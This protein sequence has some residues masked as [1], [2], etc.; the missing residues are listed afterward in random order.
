MLRLTGVEAGYGNA[1]VLREVDLTVP[2]GAVVALLG[3]NGAGKTTLLNVASGLITPT[4]GTVHLDG[5]DVVGL[6]PH[7]RA[8]RG[9]CHVPE[10]RGVFPTLTV[11]DNLELYAAGGDLDRALDAF[12][13]L[14]D[15]L[16]QVAGTLSGGEQQ[17][18]AL[19]RTYVQSP[20]IVLLDEVSM[21]LAPRLVDEI[22]GFIERLAAEGV[23]MLLV[24]QYV[25]RALEL[26]DYVY[27]LRRGRIGFAGEPVEL[28]DGDLFSHYVGS[29]QTPPT[30]VRAGAPVPL[31]PREKVDAYLEAGWWSPETWQDLLARHVAERPAEIAVVD[32]LNREDLTEGD[33]QR[34]T[35]ADLEHRVDRLAGVLAAHGIVAGDVVGFQLANGVELVQSLLAITRIGAIASPFPAQYREHELT[36]LGELAGIRVFLTSGQLLGRPNAEAGLKLQAMLPQLEHVMAWGSGLPDGVVAL[37]SATGLT[38]VDAHHGDPN[39]CTT[40]CWTS[41]TESVPKGVPRCPLDWGALAQATVDAGK[42]TSDDVL[43]NPFPMVN[44]AGIGGM[45]VPWL[46]SGARLVQH[47]P[48]DLMT[49]LKQVM[50]EEVTYT[51]A[52]PALLNVLVDNEKILSMVDLSSIRTIG[53]GSAPLSPWMIKAWRDRHGIDVTNF[54]GSNEG[55]ALIGDPG[56]IPD[57]EDRARYFPRFGVEGIEW[58][59]HRV[60]RGIRTRL[61]DLD[62]GTDITETGRP[63]E[64]RIAGPT[65]FA[66]YLHGA[67]P[68]A[69]DEQGYFGTGDVFELVSLDGGE[70]RF[71]KFVD[72]AKDV[73]IRGGMNIAPAELEALLGDHPKIAD[74]AVIGYPDDDLGERTCAVVVPSGEGTPTLGELLDHLREQQIASYKLPE[75]IEIVAVLPRNAVGKVLKRELREQVL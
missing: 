57:P 21:G 16:G 47:H 62:D 39:D 67:G 31:H 48:F 61:V 40:I 9:L 64:L 22:F 59:D 23:A 45:F 46:L 3:P 34:W 11:R 56:S 5:Q 63:G 17:M 71:L 8:A 53:S 7:Q 38:T 10:G 18:L 55:I 20:R 26:A 12:P 70:P 2:P 65:V 49:F 68:D 60:A 74:V 25:S 6:A 52:P 37:D 51:V 14:G 36:Q 15:R 75:R 28:R 41:G 43:L 50:A 58:P 69:F 13:R 66:G 73:I 35:W 54:F 29:S 32:P 1:V 33:P 30:S 44:M 24:E 27:V 19:A 42:L 72:R 4:E